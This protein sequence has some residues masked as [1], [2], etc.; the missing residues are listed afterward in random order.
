MLRRPCSKGS[1][2]TPPGRSVRAILADTILPHMSPARPDVSEFA[3]YYA[4]YVSLVPDAPLLDTLRAQ[5]D[6]WD[7]RLQ[8]ADAAATY[9]PGKWTVGQVLAHVADAERV[10]AFRMLWFARG[11]DALPGF[12]ENAWAT[13]APSLSVPDGLAAFRTAR[14]ATVSLAEGLDAEA[15]SR[16]GV[17]SGNPMSARAAAYVLAGHVLAHA[18]V[19]R[20]RYGLRG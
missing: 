5:P 19:L 16:A 9:A 12:D 11:G 20:E 3:P 10:F 7:R 15:W 4:R 18:D 6:A 17:A 8:D 13:T 2:Q 14:A 1:R